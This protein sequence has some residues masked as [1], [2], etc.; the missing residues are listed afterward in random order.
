[1]IS[2]SSDSK[3]LKAAVEGIVAKRIAAAEKQRQQEREEQKAQ[4][5][6]ALA[7]AVKAARVLDR[8]LNAS[9]PLHAS[10]DAHAPTE[11]TAEVKDLQTG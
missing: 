6:K 8:S 5:R 1:M 2:G 11:R 3:A 7:A 4:E 10:V 9:L